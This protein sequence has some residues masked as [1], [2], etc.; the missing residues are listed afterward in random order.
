MIKYENECCGCATD[1]FPCRGSTC[2]LRNVPHLIC[3]TCGAEVEEGELYETENGQ[4][5]AECAL[6][7]YE[8]VKVEG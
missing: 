7:N 1:N 5:C 3:D 8:K 2:E 4:E 6:K